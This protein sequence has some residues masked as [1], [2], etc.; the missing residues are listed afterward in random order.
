MKPTATARH[1]STRSSAERRALRLPP[2]AFALVAQSFAEGDGERLAR[3]QVAPNDL[4]PPAGG[5]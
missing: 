5:E 2:L 3:A 1:F 4:L